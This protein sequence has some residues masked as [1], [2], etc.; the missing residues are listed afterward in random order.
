VAHH[1]GPLARVPVGEGRT[2]EVDGVA[3]AVFHT[4]AGAVFATQASC[5]HR[6]GPLADGLVGPSTVVCPL[7]AYRFELGTGGA[8]GHDCG[9]L[10]T[11][12]VRVSE[13]GEL[14]VELPAR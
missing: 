9:A 5:P 3:I 12:P 14:L 7:H 1:L 8:L 4:R 11:Y 6:G 2:F 13:E 10:A